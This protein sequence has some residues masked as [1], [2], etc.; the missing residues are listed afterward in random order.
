MALITSGCVP[1]RYIKKKTTP[2]VAP[3]ES[4]VILLHPPLP[5]VGVSIVIERERQQNV[6]LTDG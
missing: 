5:L 2:K 1:F 3:D 4:S 6:S